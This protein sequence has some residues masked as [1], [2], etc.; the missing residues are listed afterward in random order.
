MKN[1]RLQKWAAV[2]EL[3]S[4][5][6]LVITIG[7][8]AFQTM[9]NTN[10]LQAQ[11]FQELIRDINDWRTLTLTNPELSAATERRALE[12]WDNLNSADQRQM[13]FRDQVIWGVYESAYF[14]NERGVLGEDE[15]ARFEEVI[16]RHYTSPNFL[17]DPPGLRSMTNVLTPKFV[18]YVVSTCE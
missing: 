1:K 2:A 3:I 4:A 9:D 12:G 10:A 13:W 11:T 16:C 5:V 15:W 6:G 8:L 18:V 14:A 7:F 17:W